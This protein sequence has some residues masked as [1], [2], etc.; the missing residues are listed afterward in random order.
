[1]RLD[2]PSDKCA[3]RPLFLTRV[4][5]GGASRAPRPFPYV[6]SLTR[7]GSPGLEELSEFSLLFDTALDAAGVSPDELTVEVSSAGAEREVRLPRDLR[8]FQGL[9]MLVRY[10]PPEGGAE[11][12]EVLDLVSYDEAAGVATWRVAD[13]RANRAASAK[14]GQPLPKK[15]RERRLALPLD[16]MRR[17]NLH[18]DV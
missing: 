14:K 5:R 12:S 16:A 2:K 3:L 8:R 7:F 18:I 11:V 1:M 15:V 10:S 13:V 17:V 4:T 9:P 6:H